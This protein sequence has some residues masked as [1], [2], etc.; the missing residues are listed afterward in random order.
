MAYPMPNK[1]DANSL[2]E[3]Y[4]ED[5]NSVA[6][7]NTFS[8]VKQSVMIS[9]VGRP[10]FVVRIMKASSLLKIMVSGELQT[11]YISN[12]YAIFEKLEVGVTCYNTRS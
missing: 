7:L 6:I 11:K 5:A 8:T 4:V 3:E 12:T 2:S 10:I 1:V 9:T